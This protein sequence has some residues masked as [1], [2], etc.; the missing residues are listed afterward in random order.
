MTSESNKVRVQ[1]HPSRDF[2]VIN[3]ARTGKDLSL[4]CWGNRDMMNLG[5]P[6]LA[7]IRSHFF[8]SALSLAAELFVD[9]KK[10][11]ACQTH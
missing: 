9:M 7:K 2:I 6:F 4:A 11:S 3:N 5:S 8:L 1:E 10:D